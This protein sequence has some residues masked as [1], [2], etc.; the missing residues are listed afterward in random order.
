[1]RRLDGRVAVVTGAGSGIGRATSELLA[2]KGCHLALVDLSEEGMR[3][4]AARVRAAGRK[5]SLHP[6]DVADKERMRSLP[7][8][9]LREHGH[10]HILVNNAGVALDSTIED[11]DLEDFEWIVGINFWG[12]VYGCK[13]FL[14]HLRR[15]DEAH[16]VNLSSM[17]G[18]MG[19]PTQGA[20]CAT[21]FAVRALS[22]ALCSE[23]AGSSVNVTLVHPG[24]IN[25][26]IVQS[27]RFS[28]EGARQ[29]ADDLLKKWN[30]SPEAAAVKIVRAIERN[31]FRVL[32]GREAYLLDWV[33]RLAP[34]LTH[35]V[36]AW[37]QRRELRAQ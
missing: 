6:A 25:T 16:L 14:P 26:N 33:K 34:V 36:L 21:K 19:L 24:V 31:K 2:R 29:R 1:M 13:F 17:F 11:H 4:T 3:E 22:E 5:V 37:R 35:R 9:V 30:R 10:V 18:F 12:V 27:G 23:L 20:Y 15:E 32:I 8:E 28:D 7:D